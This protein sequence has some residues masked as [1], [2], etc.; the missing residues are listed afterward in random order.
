MKGKISVAVDIDRFIEW[1]DEQEGG[2]LYPQM[3]EGDTVLGLEMGYTVF[4]VNIG[5]P[6]ES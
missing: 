2:T 3:E 4:F 1:L 6:E 5:S